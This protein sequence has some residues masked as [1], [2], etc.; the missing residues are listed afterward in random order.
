MSLLVGVIEKVARSESSVTAA[1]AALQ[2]PQASVEKE[3]RTPSTA[4]KAL[5]LLQSRGEILLTT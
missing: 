2:V 3:V 5:N 4:E 1:T